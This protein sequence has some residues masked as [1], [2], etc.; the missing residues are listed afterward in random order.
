MKI[1]KPNSENQEPQGIRVFLAGSIEMGKAKDWQDSTANLFY[2]IENVT[3]YNPLRENWDSS[4]SQDQKNP[5]FNYQVNWELNSIDNSHIVFFN[6]LPDTQSPITLMELG[7][8]AAT[9]HRVVVCCPEGFW[10][11]GNVDI[12][13]TRSNIQVY[14]DYDKAVGALRT[15]IHQELIGTSMI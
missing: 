8:C 4:W 7:Y 2:D 3:F 1:I 13:S 11:K 10:K 6:I 15:L 5:Q 12:I 9:K 14:E